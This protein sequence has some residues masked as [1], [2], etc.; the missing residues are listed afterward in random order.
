MLTKLKTH[1]SEYYPGYEFYGNKLAFLT[2]LTDTSFVIKPYNSKDSY[3]EYDFNGNLIKKYTRDE[4][5]A[6]F[7][8]YYNM[9]IRIRKDEIPN[10][11]QVYTDNCPDLCYHGDFVDCYDQH[12]EFPWLFDN[13]KNTKKK[14]Y[15]EWTWWKMNEIELV[16]AKNNARNTYVII[17]HHEDGSCGIASIMEPDQYDYG[18]GDSGTTVFLL[19]GSNFLVWNAG[20]CPSVVFIKNNDLDPRVLNPVSAELYEKR[21]IIIDSKK[22]YYDSVIDFLNG[23]IDQTK[24]YFS[25]DNSCEV[26]FSD[27]IE[28]INK[29]TEDKLIDLTISYDCI[30][31]KN[32]NGGEFEYFPEKDYVSTDLEPLREFINKSINLS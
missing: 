18:D 28:M 24:F 10:I 30:V 3:I 29:E 17:S 32:N 8:N 27:K 15:C 2:H 9:W 13:I 25:F 1:N 23:F 31:L 14:H 26:L 12:R 16:R 4:C 19:N 22:K 11:K 7:P 6:K 21:D 5:D 20:D